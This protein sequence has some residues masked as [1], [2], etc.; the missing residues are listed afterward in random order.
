LRVRPALDDV[1][2]ALD[3]TKMMIYKKF[4]EYGLPCPI[5]GTDGHVISRNAKG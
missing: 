5:T 1:E 2:S 3:R 4:A